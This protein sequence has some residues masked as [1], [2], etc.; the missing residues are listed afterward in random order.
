MPPDESQHY[1]E[2]VY[3]LYEDGKEYACVSRGTWAGRGAAA[4]HQG[5]NSLRRASWGERWK[6][7]LPSSC[8][9]DKDG[10]TVLWPRAARDKSYL[11]L[12]L[13]H[14][15]TSQ[16]CSASSLSTHDS[17]LEAAGFAP[18]SGWGS[19]PSWWD[20]VSQP[21]LHSVNFQRSGHPRRA[22]KEVGQR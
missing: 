11:L 1:K 13:A 17:S 18:T 10:G 6:G 2:D 5:W 14:S 8:S 7:S 15:L 4:I 21:H 20:S 9:V 12:S 16:G 3:W 22:G 19:G